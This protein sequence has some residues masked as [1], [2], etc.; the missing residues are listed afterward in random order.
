[1]DNLLFKSFFLVSLPK[2]KTECEYQGKI[3]S[4]PCP[5]FL[6]FF[7]NFIFCYFLNKVVLGETC[8]IFVV[9]IIDGNSIC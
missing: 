7:L 2:I 5:D 4:S 1:M 3:S 8:I 6:T 9:K